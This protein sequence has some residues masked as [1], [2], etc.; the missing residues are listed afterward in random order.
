MV[1]DFSKKSTVDQIRQRFDRDVERFSNLESGQEAAMDAPLMMGLTAEA[2]LAAAPRAKRLLDI[3]CGA[4]NYT[5]K[6]LQTKTDIDCDLVDL[7]A[8]MLERA[9]QRVTAK[10]SGCVRI[11]QGDI[12]HVPLDTGAYDIIIAAAVLHHLRDDGDWRQ[13]FGKLHTLCAPG[14]GLWIVD[15]IRHATPGVQELMEK[16]YK[17]YLI[18]VGGPRYSDAVMA[19]IDQEDS[20]QT[21]S[22][23]LDMLRQ[24]GFSQTEV[25]HKKGCYAA[26]GAIKPA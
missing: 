18:G 13:V 3:G 10:T 24:A 8:P 20:P 9:H 21:I 1:T 17:Q 16:E 12:R 5:L 25:L 19:V 14:G 7:S 26:F 15:L 11:F 4:G 2:A 23:Q 6:I 22:F